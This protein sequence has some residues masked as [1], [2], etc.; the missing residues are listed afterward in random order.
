MPQ[1]KTPVFDKV[2]EA[3]IERK[4]KEWEHASAPD[5]HLAWQKGQMPHSHVTAEAD[6]PLQQTHSTEVKRWKPPPQPRPDKQDA[7]ITIKPEGTLYVSKFRGS[8]AI[9]NA[10]N[11]AAGVGNSVWPIW[12]QNIIVVGVRDAQITRK[13]L[14]I[15]A[16]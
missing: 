6:M 10:M 15:Q 2:T 5:N 12:E 11:M 14:E 7:V 16:R 1:A 13:I 4:M 8:N 9:G 3:I